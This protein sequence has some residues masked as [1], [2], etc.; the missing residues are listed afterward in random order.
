MATYLL[1]EV[2]VFK[3]VNFGG[4]S[5]RINLSYSYVGGAWNDS[6][7]SIIVLSGTWT[8]CLNAGPPSASNPNWTLGPGY[9]SWVENYGIPNDAISAIYIK[10]NAP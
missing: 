9:Y 4:D 5:W 7:S 2:I 1:P 3:D 8:F 6:I 10:A